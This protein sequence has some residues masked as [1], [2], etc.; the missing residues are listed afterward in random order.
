MVKYNDA[1]I[2]EAAYYIWQNSGCPQGQDSLHWAMALE[3][4]SKASKP[5]KSCSCKSSCKSSS[6]KKSAETKAK[7][8]VKKSK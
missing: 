8:T 6:A 1:A 3:Q 2:R 7:K 4:L 5:S